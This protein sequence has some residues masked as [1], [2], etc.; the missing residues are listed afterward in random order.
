MKSSDSKSENHRLH[1]ENASLH[2]ENHRLHEENASLHAENHRLY[3]ENFIFVDRKS[4]VHK[5]VKEAL[6][7]IEN[8]IP[9]MHKNS[10]E[11]YQ[12]ELGKLFT[13]F[14]SDKNTNHS[15][16]KIYEN[17]LK[18][19]LDPQILEIGVGSLGDFPYAG[20]T[21]GGGLRAF[22]AMYPQSKL[23]GAD[24]DLDALTKIEDV[25]IANFYVDQ[26]LQSELEK[27]KSELEKYGMF[28]LIIDDGFHEIHANLRTFLTLRSILKPVGKYVIEDVH[29]SYVPLWKA[30]AVIAKFDLEIV[31]LSDERP[32]SEDNIL[33]IIS[34]N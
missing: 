26:T 23:F 6:E 34:N 5:F 31:D 22:K 4:R 21:P 29:L 18:G 11:D 33:L 16:G 27:M 19:A 13:N 32:E 20:L 25:T 8:S 7:L 30:I 2:A 28:D 1:E 15:Y 3:N 9:V 12:G 17:L 24:I 14:G 10:Y